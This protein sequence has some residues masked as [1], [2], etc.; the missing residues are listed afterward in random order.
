MRRTFLLFLVCLVQSVVIVSLVLYLNEANEDY[1]KLQKADTQ[2]KAADKE[3]QA[4]DADLKAN[5]DA[6]I[7]TLN[8]ET[9]RMLGEVVAAE[10]KERGENVEC[11]SLQCTQLT[12]G[13]IKCYEGRH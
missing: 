10:R 12:D 8:K 11:S 2:L 1:S 3:L 5:V 6:V 4:A 13:S 9:Q 7:S